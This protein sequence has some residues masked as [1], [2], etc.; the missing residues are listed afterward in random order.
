MK[1]VAKIILLFVFLLSLFIPSQSAYA[2]VAPEPE[3][4]LGSLHPFQ[5]TEVQMKYE[6]VEMELG[7]FND[8]ELPDRIQNRVTVNAYFIM[9]NLGKAD[10]SMNVVFP[11]QSAPNCHKKDQGE[12]FTYY[13]ILQDSFEVNIDG[14]ATSTFRLDAPYGECE[15]YPWLAFNTTFPVNTDVLIKVS[16][17]METQRVDYAQ[18]IDYIL[19]TGAGWKGKIGRG[20]IIFKLPYTVTSD[21]VLSGTTEGYQSLYNEIF[22]SFQD[23]EPT[24]DNNINISI[25][26]PNIWL[27]ILK[28]REQIKKKPESPDA[29]IKF[30]KYLSSDCL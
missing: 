18:N 5:N 13:S 19:D 29:W 25:V 26:S 23:L 12:R 2:D 24:P 27:E 6:R 16:Y 20:Y 21:N 4:E 3:V 8:K 7:M 1:K 17:I 15:N 10:E 9:K 28:L 14:V 30:D 22:W 11:S